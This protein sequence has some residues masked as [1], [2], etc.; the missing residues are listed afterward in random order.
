MEY[1]V[2]FKTR[3][4][5]HLYGLNHAHS[6]EDFYTVVRRPKGKRYKWAKQVISDNEDSMMVEFPTW[7]RWC[8]KGVPQ[9]LEAMFAPNPLVDK[10]GPLRAGYRAGGEARRT[11]ARTIRNFVEADEFKRRRHAVRLA[12]NLNGILTYGRFYPTLT[13]GQRSVATHMAEEMRG[14]ELLEICHEISYA[15][16]YNG[17]CG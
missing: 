16:R 10:L 15:R 13:L 7:L 17:F 1:E 12:Y 3:H 14:E 2:L 11:Y 8:D 4:G 9:A 6:D 5:S